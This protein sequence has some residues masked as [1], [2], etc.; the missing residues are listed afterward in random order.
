MVSISSGSRATVYAH[1]E[2]QHK[3]KNKNGVV[4]VTKN[5]T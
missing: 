4:P 3:K 1:Q 5:V 2:F